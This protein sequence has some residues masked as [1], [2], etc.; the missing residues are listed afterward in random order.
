[1][2]VKFI[3]EEMNMYSLMKSRKIQKKQKW[4]EINKTV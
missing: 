2:N 3:K 4:K 1:M